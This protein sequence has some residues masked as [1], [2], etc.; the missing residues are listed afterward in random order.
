MGRTLLQT[1]RITAGC[2]LAAACESSDSS[3]L[4]L[5]SGR[6]TG[7]E[8]SGICIDDQVGACFHHSQVVIDFSV[9]QATLGYLEWAEKTATPMVIGTTGLD[10]AIRER[11]QQVAS[12]VAIV[13]APNFSIGVNLMLNLAEQ[14]ARVLGEDFDVEIIEAHHRHKIDAPSGTALRLGEAVAAVLGRSLESDA[15]Y[16]R[17]GMTGARPPGS[18]GFATVR[19]GTIV[20]DHTLLFAGEG[21]RLEITHRAASRTTFAQ[22]AVR[23]AQ[24]VVS[25]APGLY[26]MQDVL[27]LRIN[28]G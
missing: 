24:W 13:Q 25:R 4:G 6:L 5:D 26:D 1:I 16:G 3:S 21:E 23:A 2:Q 11:L 12:R 20:G 27:G 7:S 14:A 10:R 19:G 15:I 8:P 18:I 9:P 28:N 17:Q 22:G